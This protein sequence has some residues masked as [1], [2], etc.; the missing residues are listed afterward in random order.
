MPDGQ[1]AGV[2]D[3]KDDFQKQ[4]QR[5][6]NSSV[7]KTPSTSSYSLDPTPPA[8]PQYGNTPIF[9]SHAKPGPY[10]TELNPNEEQQFQEW[11]KTNSVPYEDSPNP[12]YDMRGYWKALISGDPRA[13]QA[14]N[15]HFPDTWKT[16]YHKSFSNES[17]YALPTAPTWKGNKLVLNGKVIYDEDKPQQQKEKE[18]DPA[19]ETPQA[20]IQKYAPVYGVDPRLVKAMMNL[21]SGG[22]SK[23]VSSKGALGYMQLMP[24]TAR[25][26]GVDPHDPEDNMKGGI[27]YMSQLL[28]RFH[29][30]PNL[31]LA[32]YHAGAGAVEK[33]GGIPDTNDGNMATRDYV[34]VIMSRYEKM[35]EGDETP[36]PQP[37]PT[38]V[39]PPHA[40]PSKLKPLDPDPIS[41]RTTT[42]SGRQV[43]TVF[44]RS[45]FKNE[46][47]KMREMGPQAYEKSVGAKF[48]PEPDHKDNNFDPILHPF[49]FMGWLTDQWRNV[50]DVVADATFQTEYER[51]AE[52]R[53]YLTEQAN[54]VALIPEE[55]EEYKFQLKAYDTITAQKEKQGGYKDENLPW[56]AGSDVA[57]TGRAT[58]QTLTEWYNPMMMGLRMFHV[59]GEAVSAL[60]GRAGWIARRAFYVA[61]AAVGGK[62]TF[63]QAQSAY[64]KFQKG[65]TV[66]GFADLGGA[67]SVAF[68][69]AL[70]LASARPKAHPQE[71]QDETIKRIE[72]LHKTLQDQPVFQR[73]QDLV[74]QGNIRPI[75]LPNI[76]PEDSQMILDDLRARAAGRKSTDMR[77]PLE[78][79]PE[80]S[81]LP[82][83]VV[84][85]R[86]QDQEDGIG[87]QIIDAPV[88][89]PQ[90][91]E[92]RR[93]DEREK[94]TMDLLAKERNEREREVVGR[95]QKYKDDL[96]QQL[97][98]ERE[99]ELRDKRRYA[100]QELIDLKDRMEQM[101]N[102]RM[103]VDAADM[104]RSL[105]EKK[106]RGVELEPF[107]K[108]FLKLW[109]E[110]KRITRRLSGAED[111]QRT[112]FGK[113]EAAKEGGRV[114]T[115][116][117][118]RE[119]SARLNKEAAE[120][121]T[122][123]ESQ[124]KSEQADEA[125][126]RAEE[127]RTSVD[128]ERA[129]R[130]AA[131][132]TQ[133]EYPLKAPVN[134]VNGA[135][136][137]V[138]LPDGRKLSA[139]YAVIKGSDLI[140][141][142]D[143]WSFEW[144]DNY[145]PQKMQPRDYSKNREAK[146]GVMA[147]GADFEVDS[148]HNT[149]N[150]GHNGPTVIL[151]DGRAAGGN[152]R[153]MRLLR[154]Y[155]GGDPEAIRADLVKKASHFGLDPEKIPPVEDQPVLVRVLDDSPTDLESLVN[156]GQDLNRDETRGF[157]TAEQAV[158]SGDRLSQNTLEWV[159]RR[160]D[161]MG[162]EASLRELMQHRGL[163]LF[164]KLVS[165][166]VI[167][168]TK[169]AEF[170]TAK[171]ELTTKAKDMFENAMLG[172]VINDADLIATMPKS[173]RDKLFRSLAPLSK[174]KASD[175]A[176]D[177][178][179]YLE[180]AVRHWKRI[181]A[182]S[183]TLNAYGKD[184]DRSTQYM[185]FQNGKMIKE[186]IHPAV[187][188][189][190][191]Y[192]DMKPVD[193]KNGFYNY[194]EDFEGNQTTLMG[195]EPPN[196]RTAF[197]GN[198]AEKVGVEVKEGEWGTVRPVEKPVE[199]T[200]EKPAIKT[201]EEVPADEDIDLTSVPIQDLLAD[202]EQNRELFGENDPITQAYI[203]ELER[204]NR[205][206]EPASQSLD[207]TP[208]DQLAAEAA[209]KDMK[210]D[211]NLAQALSSNGPLDEEKLRDILSQ[212]PK[213]S[214]GKAGAAIAVMK[215]FSEK[216][217]GMP[218]NEWLRSKIASVKV[219]GSEPPKPEPR[220][221]VE[222][223]KEDV[224]FQSGKSR[225]MD[226]LPGFEHTFDERK[227]ALAAAQAEQ[228]RRD[229]LEHKGNISKT[230][231]EM[232]RF[233]PLF[234]GTDANPERRTLF[235]STPDTVGSTES[236]AKD[237][238]YFQQAKDKLGPNASISEVALEAQRL[239]DAGSRPEQQML[240]DSQFNL[241]PSPSEKSPIKEPVRPPI[242]DDD[243]GP[244]KIGYSEYWQIVADYAAKMRDYYAQESA[245]NSDAKK[246]SDQW[247]RSRASAQM[248]VSRNNKMR[249]R[250]ATERNRP[251]M[252][253]QGAETSAAADL[254]VT[255]PSRPGGMHVVD[256]DRDGKKVGFALLE[257]RPEL[258]A[259]IVQ[260]SVSSVYPDQ[261]G[262]GYGTELYRESAQRAR[263]AGAK[264]LVSDTNRTPDAERMWKSIQSKVG[265][266]VEFKG[267]R[268]W[269]DLENQKLFQGDE[270]KNAFE[271]NEEVK[272]LRRQREDMYTKLREARHGT[273]D[274]HYALARLQEI[275]NDLR[276]LEKNWGLY[277]ANKG[278]VEFLADG[279]AIIHLFENADVSTILHEFAH[280]ARRNLKAGDAGIV[281]GWLNVEDGVWHVHQ[282]EKFARAFEK[283]LYDGEAPIPELKNV[284]TRLRDWM[285]E[286]Y[287][288]VKGSSINVRVP[289]EIKQV[290]DR[291][292]GGD[293]IEPR[294][295]KA[296]DGSKG[297]EAAIDLLKAEI[298]KLPRG[299]EAPF[300]GGEKVD[301]GKDNPTQK[302]ME[303]WLSR[304][305]EAHV[306]EENGPFPKEAVSK[307]IDA[308]DPAKVERVRKERWSNR[309][310]ESI[311]NANVFEDEPEM[312]RRAVKVA[313]YVD[314]KKY[315][316]LGWDDIVP[317]ALVK[318]DKK[319]VSSPKISVKVEAE[320]KRM[321]R[322]QEAKGDLVTPEDRMSATK[323]AEG[324]EALTE[325][326]ADARMRVFP[327]QEQAI[328]WAKENKDKLRGIQLF[329]LQDG[330]GFAHFL[331]NDP[332]ILFQE[333]DPVEVDRRI[334]MIDERM[335]KI[336]PEAERVRLG[337]MRQELLAQKSR[338]S[339]A[340]DPPPG[341]AAPGKVIK[342][343]TPE[344][345]REITDAP[346]RDDTKRGTSDAPPELQE[347]K[348][349]ERVPQRAGESGSSE[350]DGPS[351]RTRPGGKRGTGKRDG[352]E[353][354][355]ALR[356]VAAPKLDAPVHDRGTELYTQEQWTERAKLLR[357]PTN[358]PAPT[359][360]IPNSLRRMLIFPGQSE[361]VESAL[362]G[363]KQHDAYIIA[364]TTGTGKTYT[365]A[366]VL[367]Q[368]HKPGM[369]TLVLTTSQDLIHDREKGWIT[370]ARDFDVDLQE[371]PPGV[372]FPDEPG[373]Y[374]TTYAT[375]IG[376]EGIEDGNWDLILSDEIGEA[377]KWYSSQRGAM[378]KTMGGNAGK[379]LYM[380]A[381]PFHTALEIGHMDKLGLWREQGWGPW[382]AQFG[383]YRDAEGNW[384]G[385]NAPKKLI[386]LR[387]QLIERGQF[388][389]VDRNMDGFQTSFAQVP[390]T[391]E[392]ITDIGRI[393]EAFTLA[394]EYFKRS[395][396][397]A[398]IRAVKA[399]AATYVKKYL[400]R[401]RLP[402]A[403]ELMKKMDKEGWKV[404]LFSETKAE[405]SEIFDFL[406]P[407][408]EAMGGRL[409]ELLPPLP[410][411]PG[412]L[413]KEFGEQ[414]AN[415]SGPHSAFRTSEKEN[416]NK[417]DK[418][419][420]YVSYAA[421]GIG[422]S[423][424]DTSVGGK[425]PRAVI[426]LGPPYSGVM[427]DQAIGRAWRYG[428]K[429]NVHAVFMT[430]NSRPEIRLILEKVAPRMS[431]LRALVSGIDEQD[432]F[433]N[434]L[435]NMD[436]TREGQLAYDLGQKVKVD[437][438]DFAET[439]TTHAIQ[440]WKD[441]KVE[442]ATTAMNKGMKFPEEP[443]GGPGVIRLFQ[444]DEYEPPEDLELPE[445]HTA[446]IENRDGRQEFLGSDT[447]LPQPSRV[448]IAED[449][450]QLAAAEVKD[451]SGDK[452]AAVKFRWDN[453]KRYVMAAWDAVEGSRPV[454]AAK[455]Q[456]LYW[457]TNGRK[458]IRDM[459]LNLGVPEIGVRIARMLP[460]YHV[461]WGNIAGPWVHNY[462]EILRE[463]DISTKRTVKFTDP[464]TGEEKETTE[465]HNLVM[466]KQGKQPPA[467]RRI[468]KAVEQT[469][470]LLNEVKARLAKEN[471]AV[472]I[473]DDGAKRYVPFSQIMDDPHYWPR[474]FDPEYEIK[475][476]DPDTGQV[477]VTK[478]KDIIGGELGD[479]KR[480][481]IIKHM[482]KEYGMSLAQAEDFMESKTRDVPLVGNVERARE[483]DLPFYRTDPGAMI[484]YLEGAGEAAART[485]IFG[486]RREKLEREV[487]K[488]PDVKARARVR[489]IMD[490]VLSKR[491]FEDETKAFVSFAADW[492]V[493]TKMGFSALK[494]VGHSVHAAMSSNTRAYVRGLIEASTNWKD[495]HDHAVISG[496]ILEQYK[497]EMLREYGA[498]RKLSSK[499]LD[500]VG[501]QGTYEFG[502]VA[503]DATARQFLERY[504]LPKLTKGKGVDHY[505]RQLK[506][507]YQLDDSSIDLAI[508]RGRWMEEDFNRAGKALSDKTMFTFD[509]SELPPAWRARSKEP[510]ADNVMGGVRVLTLLKG[511]MF[512][513][514]ALLRE[515]LVDEAKK[516]NFRPLMPF[517]LL[518]PAMGELIADLTAL[519]T[520][521]R[522]RY[523]DLMNN[524][525]SLPVKLLYRFAGD[526]AHATGL[527]IIDTILEAAF[528]RHN[529]AYSSRDVY[530]FFGGPFLADAIHTFVQLPTEVMAADSK[531]PRRH[532]KSAS[533]KRKNAI[534]RWARATFPV[535]SP[536]FN[537]SKED[538][539]A[540]KSGGSDYHFTPMPNH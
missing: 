93:Q 356:D 397:K 388:M 432:K 384:A 12:D 279:R 231:G 539:K 48:D 526:M 165:D 465:H 166:G 20:Y 107:E 510:I 504:A 260:M 364:T 235:D 144:N 150:T 434:T 508:Q 127:I 345:E 160:L 511:Y 300:G 342:L 378:M 473:Y 344:G 306:D 26:L 361:V 531:D 527:T 8:D 249:E 55:R 456:D 112:R 320:A 80:T 66:G 142:H 401:S 369:R 159:S 277:Q 351:G 206:N 303:Y 414:L 158:M 461:E 445:E 372:S 106:P 509:P 424:H 86:G 253:F 120:A 464:K 433:V 423:L 523:D 191:R 245:T 111:A 229:M 382:S 255:E 316:R 463:N 234:A 118:L 528:R 145:V 276:D 487:T 212:H 237:N 452:I 58:I 297:N 416:F 133:Q 411:V 512:K 97:A 501:F 380:S 22:N 267:N 146:T 37:T 265:D 486:Q 197:N 109:E 514:T 535:T 319:S 358:A 119:A 65:D 427:F 362:S 269:L 332:N 396:K 488:L 61:N 218:F 46:L 24:D 503:A 343:W 385:G 481:K 43:T 368:L 301:F 205:A 52:Y 366:A 17:M 49:K 489:E 163:E 371:L 497:T 9:L 415:Y 313:S 63:D 448:A 162:D 121:S 348:R 407:A 264:Y 138:R 198:V 238:N 315:N 376:R 254:N 516:G 271:N 42:A 103:F 105:L 64:E 149:D 439:E 147:G 95:A 404:I 156:L 410:D 225:K 148:F 214:A 498:K 307:I 495:A 170:I 286:V 505:R 479:S 386:K 494:A 28:Q 389:N 196:P 228:L 72:K 153:A 373:A 210:D 353:P 221:T 227:D 460:E 329:T 1:G 482:M 291:M 96:E 27:M 139:R 491:A 490:S 280:V 82:F 248:E 533:E 56:Y 406:Q 2:Q 204:R 87:V 92:F 458:V 98:L 365:G 330:R 391:R 450:E 469:T 194:I 438:G 272:I 33:A 47:A 177:F 274:H 123:E 444:D 518:Y 131:K 400:E 176:W 311:L 453:T 68:M 340:L 171:G 442:P 192:L 188:A 50:G 5:M 31:A 39:V 441:V 83:N 99:L 11:V 38:A 250:A 281:E 200:A 437:A 247:E 213:Y 134:S 239:K 451:D 446:T 185:E 94:E 220:P 357:L 81:N 137:T 79:E 77:G 341:N 338:Q 408:D 346:S 360:R 540:K 167:S 4:L 128:Q 475:T 21:E 417:G 538:P 429:S 326:M 287:Q 292:M 78:G 282:E 219:G 321:Q 157:S 413:E 354:R 152:G 305:V 199:K 125:S 6:R 25:M 496:A 299:V 440:N 476:T 181:E 328:K 472:E 190:I 116:Q 173:I 114:E 474:K 462:F 435:R 32:A 304:V 323:I 88:L 312:R 422:V 393:N 178:T 298:A 172:K 399:N 74:K 251:D 7:A 485:K 337:K 506:E 259:G 73:V 246:W 266:S 263:S 412:M 209:V 201:Q 309:E 392:Q 76:T 436:S 59:G 122:P 355:K 126:K 367:N 390:L 85:R 184:K 529:A 443:A 57:T 470:K 91:R 350:Q 136:T 493:L 135:T 189:L 294:A 359:V 175:A 129:A 71:I 402:Q 44:D 381:T 530:E 507:V 104:A 499:F 23:A 515:R 517:L 217:L 67:A 394:E 324:G 195:V 418:K 230:A 492:S 520:A 327:D 275:N 193:I 347:P 466:A 62:F 318:A 90:E 35:R 186:P 524:K 252:L 117:K 15:K 521:N 10:K 207:P 447:P 30:D 295:V 403:I 519:F 468:A 288:K 349:V 398:K 537:L 60:S 322:I 261:R 208:A 352:D 84:D 100:P 296:L 374:A 113:E 536:L 331:P 154:A 240:I 203:K 377:R 244:T 532:G 534:L 310:M 457:M 409:S 431:S 54:N 449:A 293:S 428:T 459:A 232:E 426:Y 183:E 233:S 336:I 273:E 155:K 302:D 370:V 140:I 102:Q 51:D 242:M 241:D 314:E 419:H 278:A 36:A 215:S 290:F 236:T 124:A 502:R 383:V 467:N 454:K 132:Q 289:D 101:A 420:I 16:P 395:G 202:I 387:E 284:F 334:R 75:I 283:Y 89:S 256:L 421:G 257:G 115:E 41:Y 222:T 363:L 179:D 29:G 513:T 70:G 53:K 18:G 335:G 522:K 13:R 480:R 110:R 161:E 333:V 3:L 243:D 339:L 477:E 258:K 164:E 14:E 168:P 34:K 216:Y 224:L 525:E 151:S 375:A 379:I 483:Y 455:V 223:P 211:A 226:P 471:V 169:R 143:P 317:Y 270:H 180:E 285:I 108:D 130:E 478:L 45:E 405:R 484:S 174:I 325:N 268:Y 425:R 500:A 182:L 40:N 19:P 308:I 262:K 69:T 141:S 187:E 430:S